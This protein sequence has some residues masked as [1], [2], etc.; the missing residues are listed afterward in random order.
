MNRATELQNN[1]GNGMF[2]RLHDAQWIENKINE[3]K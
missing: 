3:K 2:A 1:L